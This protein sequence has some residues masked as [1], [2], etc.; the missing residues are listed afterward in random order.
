MLL[1][2]V[3]AYRVVLSAIYRSAFHNLQCR[4]FARPQAAGTDDDP[5]PE[6]VVRVVQSANQKLVF[7]QPEDG[8]W[9]VA[10]FD[11]HSGRSTAHKAVHSRES[12][13][14]STLAFP[15]SAKA[16]LEVHS[17]KSASRTRTH[18][19]QAY[20]YLLQQGYREYRLFH[21]SLASNLERN[22]KSALQDSLRAFFGEWCNRKLV[23]DSLGMPAA[24]VILDHM[25]MP[26]HSE[27]VQP[28]VFLHR[29]G[30]LR[31]PPEE[32]VRRSDALAIALHIFGL[33]PPKSSEFKHTTDP[34]QP[35]SRKQAKSK[36]QRVRRQ[37]STTSWKTLGLG[38]VG[39][40][41][42][43]PSIPGLSSS[44]SHAPS[45]EP[46]LILPEKAAKPTE[47]TDW[48]A[49]STFGMFGS[50]SR[51]AS[52]VVVDKS[53]KPVLVEPGHS[54]VKST[55]VARR[56]AEEILAAETPLPTSPTRK[57]ESDLK[58]PAPATLQDAPLTT[59]D[60][61]LKQAIEEEMAS[62]GSE[63]PAT[64]KPADQVRVLSPRPVFI[65]EDVVQKDLVCM[66]LD[67][68][69]LALLF[70]LSSSEQKEDHS[71]LQD[72]SAAREYLSA[73][74]SSLSPRSNTEQAETAPQ[75]Y[76]GF[77]TGTLSVHNTAL[78]STAT[79]SLKRSSASSA[80]DAVSSFARLG[81]ADLYIRN[82]LPQWL[83]ARSS[84]ERGLD[85][86]LLPKSI[87]KEGSLLDAENEMS[88]LGLMRLEV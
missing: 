64:A 72:L 45:T 77:T 10:A 88:R 43:V 82:S 14:A 4:S 21:G 47:G 62:E 63:P 86:T 57:R 65:G 3:Y 9:M 22:G 55:S 48:M 8:Y 70:D 59:V 56:S 66:V 61:E 78:P 30:I 13:S 27:P 35:A 52:T 85:I 76:Y 16:S 54:A 1:A 34:L 38:Q 32:D 26:D 25:V 53:A 44:D 11:L 71:R 74:S 42:R 40:Y 84:S 23:P 80:V 50:K 51:K 29:K 5:A 6:Q 36:E 75:Q 68:L 60:D 49:I 7:L 24:S 81:V 69:V 83:V 79:D 87:G 12:S 20:V 67:D 18:S 33:L 58:Q 46:V 39:S 28:H 2:V 41:L 37:P 31:L 15:T 73:V 19:N 17:A